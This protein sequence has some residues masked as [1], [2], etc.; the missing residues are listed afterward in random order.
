MDIKELTGEDLNEASVV[1]TLT[2]VR[3]LRET[4]S[5]SELSFSLKVSETYGDD[6]RTISEVDCVVDDEKQIMKLLGL[7]LGRKLGVTGHL[8]VRRWQRNSVVQSRCY[9]Q[10]EQLKV[11]AKSVSK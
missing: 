1:G 6:K 4:E 2:Y 11:F 3:Q 5:G 8:N 10:V 9:L 7:D